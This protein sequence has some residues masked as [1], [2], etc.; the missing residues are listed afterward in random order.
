M[1]DSQV[2]TSSGTISGHADIGSPNSRSRHDTS[3]PITFVTVTK[4]SV[5][6]V[7]QVSRDVAKSIHDILPWENLPKWMQSDPYIRRGYRRQYN[8]FSAC[9]Q[10]LFYLHNE[11]VNIWSHLL[12]TLGYF[13]TLIRTDY[14]ILHSGVQISATDNAAVQ[15]YVVASVVCLLFSVCLF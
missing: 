8:S 10:S 6:E 12:P 11:T 9:L 1:S 4:H 7:T 14:S 3:L 2:S 15:S 5:K 13:L